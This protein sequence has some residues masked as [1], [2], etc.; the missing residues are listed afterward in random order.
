MSDKNNN[1]WRNLRQLRYP[2]EFRIDAPSW[3]ESVSDSLNEIVQLMATPPVPEAPMGTDEAGSQ[4]ELIAKLGTG[5]WALRSRILPLGDQAD[6][7]REM[8]TLF[9]TF[10][11]TWNEFIQQGVEVKDH[12]GERVVG[13]EAFHIVGSQ[14]MPEVA[15]DQVI[16]TISPSIYYQDRLIQRGE[17]LVG[18]P[19]TTA[20]PSAS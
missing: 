3:P 2:L 14:P 10:Q 13:G 18:T 7:S 8:R 6:L 20:T 15:C 17:V 4:E 19:Q 16:R 9:L 11:S 1:L 12:T 5:L